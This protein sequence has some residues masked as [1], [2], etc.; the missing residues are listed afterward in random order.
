MLAFLYDDE[1]ATPMEGLRKAGEKLDNS[2]TWKTT[3]KW[4]AAGMYVGAFVGMIIIVGG[5][6]QT[7]NRVVLGNDNRK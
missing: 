1:A 6:A 5:V 2:P 7:V 3:K 4:G